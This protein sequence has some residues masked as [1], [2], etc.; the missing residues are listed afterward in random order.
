MDLWP[1]DKVVI[2]TGGAKGIGAAITRASIG[3]YVYVDRAL[4]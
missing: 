2:I 1:K 3:G 4:T